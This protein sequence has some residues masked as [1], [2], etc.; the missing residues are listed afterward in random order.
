MSRGERWELGQAARQ[1]VDLLPAKPESPLASCLVVCDTYHDT[2][3]ARNTR[4][5]LLAEAVKA[6]YAPR[7]RRGAPA[8]FQIAD[9]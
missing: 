4:R 9:L 8:G 2:V 6:A 1:A 5:L 3:G 7:P